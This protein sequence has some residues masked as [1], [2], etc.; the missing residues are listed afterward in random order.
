MTKSHF[1]SRSC[2]EIILLEA[3]TG[4]ESIP[5][6][7]S[8]RTDDFAVSGCPGFFVLLDWFFVFFLDRLSCSMDGSGWDGTAGLFDVFS[9]LRELWV[10]PA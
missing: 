9:L 4:A 6:T 2:K 5:C 10:G 7:W 8:I 3:R 1:R